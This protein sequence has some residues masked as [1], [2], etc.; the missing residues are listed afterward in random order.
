LAR[1][2][3]CLPD[4]APLSRDVGNAPGHLLQ[5][6][7]LMRTIDDGGSVTLI[8]LPTEQLWHLVVTVEVQRS[9][10]LSMEAP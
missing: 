6:S 5:W 9:A 7:S 4:R 3:T 8:H 2:V 1:I 10:Q